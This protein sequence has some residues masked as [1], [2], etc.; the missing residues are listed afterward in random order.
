MNEDLFST[1]KPKEEEANEGS[2]V[3]QKIINILQDYQQQIWIWHLNT[4]GHWHQAT[5]E[6]YKGLMKPLDGLGESYVEIVGKNYKKEEY[7]K[8]LDE[9]K[10]EDVKVKTKALIKALNGFASKFEDEGVKG[11]IGE[12][13][14]VLRS[15]TFKF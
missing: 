10:P 4:K 12:I 3:F 9:F 6:A 2:A 13:I 14:N 7:P 11:Y 5:D 1:E 8:L 15:M